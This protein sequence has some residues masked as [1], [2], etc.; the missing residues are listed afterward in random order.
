MPTAD[1]MGCPSC[2]VGVPVHQGF[3]TWCAACNW[4][5]VARPREPRAPFERLL[6]RLAVALDERVG[7]ELAVAETLEPRLTASKVAAY[8]VA[9][10]VHAFTASLVVGA[11]VLALLSF[12]N[13]FALAGAAVALGFAWLVRP[14]LG[15]ASTKGEVKHGD[16]PALHALVEQ[17]ADALGARPPDAV[18]V[19]NQLNA[20][21]AV[22]GLR[23]RRVLTLGLP[24]IAALTTQELVALVAHEVA[25]ER[26]RD[27]RRSF[28]VGSA[29]TTLEE[30]YLTLLPG[31]S[32]LTYSALGVLDMV[33]RLFF[34]VL[35]QPVKGLLLVEFHLL[36]QD[37]QRAEY[38]ADSLAATVAGTDAVV[39]MHEVLLLD[40]TIETAVHNAAHGRVEPGALF[41]TI[42]ER[43][44]AV[45]AVERERV[46]RIAALERARLGATHPTT[47]AR[48]GLL[49]RRASVQPE[50][51]VGTEIGSAIKRELANR[52]A[53]YGQRLIDRYRGSLY[54]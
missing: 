1:V 21:W 39:S 34:W 50:V 51:L 8:A 33:A 2:G 27:A 38:L 52:H 37:M 18:V 45:P 7:R 19:D 44:G 3:V 24:L 49:E 15:K 12:P 47:A 23:R 9:G 14:R 28:F 54:R 29:L 20:A 25:H 53:E 31:E 48:I 36:L 41:A 32:L 10:I 5:L 17:V 22:V 42:A 30:V 16:A 43:I 6:E 4:N 35:A 46:R 26:N 11:L 13:P 40:A